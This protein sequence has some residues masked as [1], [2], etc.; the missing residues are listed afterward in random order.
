AYGLGSRYRLSLPRRLQAM[1]AP[2]PI[3][4]MSAA[5]HGHDHVFSAPPRGEVE[6]IGP[7]APPGCSA[8][9]V[10]TSSGDDG[11]GT[12]GMADDACAA[13]GC[14]EVAPVAR[15]PGSAPVGMP[16]TPFAPRACTAIGITGEAWAGEDA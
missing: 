8:G 1:N 13:D 10:L 3:S 7:L 4:A 16:A 14:R 2:P 15:R 6:G 9:P 12:S 5:S 11:V